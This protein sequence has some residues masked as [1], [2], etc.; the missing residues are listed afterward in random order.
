MHL[1]AAHRHRTH[2]AARS[3][4]RASVLRISIAAVMWV[5][6]VTAYAASNASALTAP[7]AASGG[8]R[9]WSA[10]ETGGVEPNAPVAKTPSKKR[11]HRS[12][13]PVITGSEL[14][15]STML[16]EGRPITLKYRVKA[17]AGRVRVSLV[18][19]TRGGKY[20]ATVPL[21]LH[22]T[23]VLQTTDLTQAQLG[24]RRAGS[25][26]LRLAVTDRNGRRAA[27]ASGV[28]QWL[29]FSFA[30]HRFPVVGRFT[31][32]GPDARFGAGRP[33]HIHQGQDVVADE[34][35]PL[36]APHAGTISWVKYQADGAGYYIVL[37]STD[38][39]DYV[40]M[41]L[42]E[43]STEVKQGDVVP[44]GKLRSEEHTSELQSQ[45]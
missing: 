41:H 11:R 16:D 35:T 33:G 43:G 37:H 5:L 1:Q 19:R 3:R 8:A 17:R 29:T 18:V 23:R 25:Y 24:V 39:R 38:G 27:R 14:T 30:D 6:L 10:A 42:K 4:R 31:F 20:I 28:D 13:A 15:T 36:V 9:Y 21:G 34:G 32:G 45:R 40:F 44:T 7:L 26:K 2:F 22:K 12:A